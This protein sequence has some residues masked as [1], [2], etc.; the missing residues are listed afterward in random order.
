MC[1]YIYIRHD[2]RRSNIYG[3]YLDADI[4]GSLLEKIY[5]GI[6]N[7]HNDVCIWEYTRAR[8]D[9]NCIQYWPP[10]Q[11][12]NKWSVALSLNESTKSFMC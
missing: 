6:Y 8:V 4:R 5:I 10:V 12:T 9:V 1:V 2:E 7:R 3:A 11:Q